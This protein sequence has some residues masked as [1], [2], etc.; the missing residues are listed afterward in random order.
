LIIYGLSF[1]GVLWVGFGIRDEFV[2]LSDLIGFSLFMV[3]PM[4]NT[5]MLLTL[6]WE[7]SKTVKLRKYK[8]D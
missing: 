6:G 5:I 3:V 2:A 4:L 7:W 8:N 1:L